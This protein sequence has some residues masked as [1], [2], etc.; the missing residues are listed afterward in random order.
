MG[1]D[2][3]VGLA[4]AGGGLQGFS[5]IGALKALE[6]LGIKVDYISGTSTGSIVAALYAIGYTPDE[7]T[8]ICKENYNRIFKPSKKLIFKIGIN[9]FL[10]KETRVEGLI[11][12]QLIAEFINKCANKKG[13][14]LISDI[15]NKTVA[16]ATVDTTT[17]KE[18]IFISNKGKNNLDNID[19][20]SD[21]SIGE[22]VRSSMAFP[23]IFTT[24]N[25][26]DYNFIDG[27][28]I[29]N[30]PVGI[31][32][33]MGAEKTIAISFDLNKYI[34]SK[35]LEGVI[36]RA[37]DIFSL[38]SVKKGRMLSDINVEIY[39]PDAALISIKDMKKTIENGYNAV[40]NKRQEILS[41]LDWKENNIND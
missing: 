28:T 41:I 1:K 14:N 21:I 29:N 8:Q 9:Y 2:F 24:S 6:E 12:G 7:I 36:L 18:C 17:M 16:I 25:Y 39:N 13:V 35:N 31:L 26:K 32:K 23:G 33:E 40:M 38:T 5:H 3:K 4:L 11:D 22:A 15:Q 37:L 27:G 10:H 34:P 20:I 19:Y 30:L